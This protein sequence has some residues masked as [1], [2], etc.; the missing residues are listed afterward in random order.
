MKQL[1][2]IK[3]LIGPSSFAALDRY[4]M[5]LLIENGFEVIDNP[6]KRKLTKKELLNLLSEDV[7][8]LIAGLEPLDREVLEKTKLK[9]ISRVGSGLSNIDLDAAKEFGIEVRYTPYGPTNAVAELSVGIMLNI[10]R[11]VPQMNKALHSKQWNK[12]IGSQ[13][14]GK[15][16]VIIGFGRIGRRVAELLSA[17]GV[18]LLIV[19]PYIESLDSFSL[20][21]LEEAL[22][23][24]DIITLHSSGESCIIGDA[25]FGL[26]KK[27]VFILNAARGGL[28]S[29]AALI[30]ALNKGVVAGAWLDTF[31]TEPYTGPLIKYDQVVL[32]PHIGSYAAECR[33]RMETEAVENLIKSTRDK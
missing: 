2:K 22:P 27:G 10:I 28:V 32:T 7:T 23:I 9:V 5:D 19:D 3:V 18:K 12:M 20:V 13:L 25:E 31:E 17:F 33:R 6:F 26:V 8:A 29:E 24:A 15:N 30:K 4:P 14:E 16:V 1:D 21:S 11:M